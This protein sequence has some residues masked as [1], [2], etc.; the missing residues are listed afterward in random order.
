MSLILSNG[1]RLTL[2]DART[3]ERDV[4]RQL[5]RCEE[6][7]QMFTRLWAHRSQ[8][9]AAVAGHLGLRSSSQCVVQS[10][11]VWNRGHFN[12]CVHVQVT[13]NCGDLSRKIF[14]CPMPHKVGQPTSDAIDEKIRSEA[15]SYAWVEQECPDIPVPHL[16]GF[17]LSNG[18]KAKR[19]HMI[20]CLS[21]Y[22]PQTSGTTE[23]RMGYML[24]DFMHTGSMLSNTWSEGKHDEE[25]KAHLYRGLSQIMLS[26]ARQ[27]QRRIG[28]LRFN[29][30]GSISLASRPLLCAHSILE[31]EGAPRMEGLYST[32]G[33]FLQALQDFRA[34]AFASQAN[35]VHDEEDCRLQMSHMVLLRSIIPQ[36]I[37]LPYDGPFALQFTDLHASNIFVDADWNITGIIDLEFICSLP[38]DMLAVPYWLA[39][40][41]IDDASEH[42][43][44]FTAMYNSFVQSFSATEKR[45][46]KHHATPLG[47]AMHEALRTGA[48]WV[49]RCFTSIDAMPSIIEDQICPL[50]GFT[51]TTAEEEAFAR[52]LSHFWCPESETFV[53]RKLAERAQYNLELQRHYETTEP[54]R[55]AT[56][57]IL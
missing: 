48:Y 41:Y 36:L 28:S 23:L 29:D 16:I 39:V 13:D 51:S 25:K 2:E 21:Q 42:R 26:L 31:S 27:P 35:A 45:Q 20:P 40:E 15:A 17:G 43:E 24:M 38:P 22:V 18:E 10:P 4:L 49:Y 50:F 14:R 7:S 6:K 3:E 9:Q 56:H 33:Q 46:N 55:L 34:S 52:S 19:S 53:Q 30:D 1:R 5:R 12:I 47:D 8:I 32:S 54:S 57:I 11:A 44:E 37:N